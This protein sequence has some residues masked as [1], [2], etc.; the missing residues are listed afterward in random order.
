MVKQVAMNNLGNYLNKRG[1]YVV[2]CNA[3]LEGTNKDIVN[4]MRQI[5]IIFKDIKFL[6]VKWKAFKVFYGTLPEEN[7][8]IIYAYYH[9]KLQ[10]SQNVTDSKNLIPFF[11]K[12]A[13]L[14][15]RSLDDKINNVG[16]K[17][18][19]QS[20]ITEYSKRRELQFKYNRKYF[21]KKKIKLLWGE[22]PNGYPKNISECIN[23]SLINVNE[24][25][26]E[27]S[28]IILNH[29][30]ELSSAQ[31]CQNEDKIQNSDSVD[32]YKPK[33]IDNISQMTKNIKGYDKNLNIERSVSPINEKSKPFS[34]I[35]K[36][37]PNESLNKRKSL[38]PK[39]RLK[40]CNIPMHVTKYENEFRKF[41]LK[42][43][44]NS[45]NS[46]N[47]KSSWLSESDNK[48]KQD[49]CL[50]IKF[51][52][53]KNDFSKINFKNNTPRNIICEF[54][55]KSKMNSINKLKAF[56]YKRRRKSLTHI[57]HNYCLSEDI[58]FK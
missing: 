14:Y 33:I 39:K 42:I 35:S 40:E 46:L 3:E 34:H 28:S 32:I 43:S 53:N 23:K 45:L 26:P 44:N 22:L 2:F 7:M 27:K 19:S 31:V 4:D 15:N 10:F 24:I 8:N 20:Q 49:E 51:S 41:K 18:N 50:D 29:N 38:P 54:Q 6:E 12:L 57:E 13:D 1:P 11:Q 16:S 52:I 9:G 36:L 17:F 21:N 58:L 25:K 48:N 55:N 56:K 5:E 37:S 30:K 47:I